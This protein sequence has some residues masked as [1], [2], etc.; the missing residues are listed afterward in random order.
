MNFIVFQIQHSLRGT[1]RGNRAVR[2]FLEIARLHQN[3]RA[4]YSH[5]LRMR[6]FMRLRENRGVFERA[7]VRF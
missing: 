3:R 6:G 5:G 1:F 2:P 4:E 7:R